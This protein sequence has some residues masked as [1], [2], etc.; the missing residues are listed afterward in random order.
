MLFWGG[1]ALLAQQGD[2]DST[3]VDSSDAAL[4]AELAKMLS[5]DGLDLDE[6]NS[7]IPMPV[8]AFAGIS[9]NMN[10]NIG[11]IPNLQETLLLED[12]LMKTWVSDFM[13]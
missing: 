6:A 9:S 12:N 5:E 11:I 10:P 4:E 8:L 1:T 13:K 3:F 7:E 2:K